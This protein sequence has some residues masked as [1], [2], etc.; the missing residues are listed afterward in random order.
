V[1]SDALNYHKK[2]AEVLEKYVEGTG[3]YYQDVPWV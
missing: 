1:E 2:N 3:E